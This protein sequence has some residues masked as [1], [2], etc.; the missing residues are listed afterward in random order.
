MSFQ[1]II[2]LISRSVVVVCLFSRVVGRFFTPRSVR[3]DA[4]KPI[5]EVDTRIREEEDRIRQCEKDLRS[6]E[7]PTFRADSQNEIDEC[8]MRLTNHRNDRVRIIQEQ[9]R[10]AARWG[11]C[12]LVTF[13]VVVLAIGVG[14]LK[15]IAD[16]KAEATRLAALAKAR[17]EVAVYL[18]GIEKQLETVSDTP[19]TFSP[20]NGLQK[21]NVIKRTDSEIKEDGEQATRAEKLKIAV[22]DYNRHIERRP[23]EIPY[24]TA[25]DSADKA[26][27][28]LPYDPTLLNENALQN[29]RENA[30]SE[31]DTQNAQDLQVEFDRIRRVSI[32]QL[33]GMRLAEAKSLLEEKN[34]DKA[35]VPMEAARKIFDSNKE[36]MRSGAE[37]DL[38][39]VETKSQLIVWELL[40]QTFDGMLTNA[41]S[42]LEKE[43]VDNAKVPMEAARKLY[44]DNK[45][46]MLPGA[47][48]AL[49][50]AE[51]KYK[52]IIWESIRQSFDGMMTNA[53]SFLDKKDVA[54]TKIPM[55]TARKFFDDNKEAMRPEDE[56][57][58]L[59]LENKYA[60]LALSIENEKIARDFT[61]LFDRI[62]KSYQ[63]ASKNPDDLRDELLDVNALDRAKK[64]IDRVAVADQ[65][66][67][68][69]LEIRCTTL[70]NNAKNHRSQKLLATI[71][72][73]VSEHKQIIADNA[74]TPSHRHDALK[75][76]LDRITETSRETEK[77]SINRR[78]VTEATQKKLDQLLAN[79]KNDCQEVYPQA[80]TQTVGNLDLYLA[81]LQ[82]V[83][84]LKDFRSPDFLKVLESPASFC[85]E[86]TRSWN[87][88][89][90][91]NAAKL[92]IYPPSVTVTEKILALLDRDAVGLASVP[93]MALMQANRPYYEETVVRGQ[94]LR[95]DMLRF[96][97]NN[98]FNNPYLDSINNKITDIADSATSPRQATLAFFDLLDQIARDKSEPACLR[99]FVTGTLVNNLVQTHQEY[100]YLTTSWRSRYGS[101]QLLTSIFDEDGKTCP[102]CK[103]TAKLL[104]ELPTNILRPIAQ[105]LPADYQK[106]PAGQSV[107]PPQELRDHKQAVEYVWVGWTDRSEENPQKVLIR[108]KQENLPK[109]NFESALYATLP[110]AKVMAIVGDLTENKAGIVPANNMEIRC[111]TPVY[112]RRQQVSES[113][114]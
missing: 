27:N 91:E 22:G 78:P 103:E 64:L 93:E 75:E 29:A 66:R 107:V 11:T 58:L 71:E 87:Q 56:T 112:V 8:N 47:E 105:K 61:A 7:N 28:D 14:I 98:K 17:Q 90:K 89:V 12:I 9:E 33:F 113:K 80:I 39:T 24:T 96:R 49:L 85:F 20:E 102:H 62:E 31:T 23:F 73:L 2:S 46:G 57:A 100:L 1:R 43:D 76:L 44:D 16:A 106:L 60:L 42:L 70:V 4:N 92:D 81:E 52:L 111:G 109:A 51:N 59:E 108:I 30:Q 6:T 77:E 99:L 48:S 45:E 63:D 38:Q 104:A 32:Q 110:G 65:T 114:P 68:S 34:V 50:A 53:N 26:K 55:E 69:E 37:D 15:A 101:F 82:H 83:S 10:N 54:K 97:L 35:K 88:F 3:T 41:K 21:L 5:Q 19:I 95:N 94:K 67:F 72:L 86:T 18:G 84:S 25:K 13:L 79:V 74:L 36:A 40:Q